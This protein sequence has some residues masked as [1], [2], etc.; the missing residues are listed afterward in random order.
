[1]LDSLSMFVLLFP[2]VVEFGALGPAHHKKLPAPPK[3]LKKLSYKKQK[4]RNWLKWRA[5]GQISRVVNV[6][7]FPHL[8]LPHEF[9]CEVFGTLLVPII[10]VTMWWAVLT[11]VACYPTISLTHR[12]TLTRALSL[13]SIQPSAHIILPCN[14]KTIGLF[15]HHTSNYHSFYQVLTRVVTGTRKAQ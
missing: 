10:L 2:Q 12:T 4:L 9:W 13:C 1:M 15:S 7:I 14:H 3:E 6:W 11:I 8:F 5:N